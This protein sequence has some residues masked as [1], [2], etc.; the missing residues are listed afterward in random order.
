MAK[1][2]GRAMVAWSFVPKFVF[3]FPQPRCRL[4]N[5]T[6]NSSPRAVYSSPSTRVPPQFAPTESPCAKPRVPRPQALAWSRTCPESP[7]SARAQSI[8]RESLECLQSSPR[9]SLQRPAPRYPHNT[10][11]VFKESLECP[12]SK[13]S[14]STQ[15]QTIL[16]S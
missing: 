6:L 2:G 5:C 11:S 12:T 3:C 14:R 1:V 16:E 13:Y 8:V 9:E 15:P 10:K 4:S 7:C